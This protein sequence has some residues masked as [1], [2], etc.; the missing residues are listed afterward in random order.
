MTMLDRASKRSAHILIQERQRKDV[1]LSF[2]KGRLLS[3]A[4]EEIGEEFAVGTEGCL[5]ARDAS[6]QPVTRLRYI[7]GRQGARLRF[8]KQLV[9]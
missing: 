8:L 2:P 4:P 1:P 3:I 6:C 9:G 7:L 5:E